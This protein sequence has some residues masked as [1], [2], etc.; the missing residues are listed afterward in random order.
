MQP[1]IKDLRQEGYKVRVIHT[2]L[3]KVVRRLMGDAFEVSSRGGSTTIEVTT[4]DKQYDVV[5]KSICSV[6]D[7][8]NRKV[9]NSIALGRALKNL[10]DLKTAEG[11]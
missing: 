4:P 3:Q 9:G 2:R 11:L 7:N 1:T 10:E 5:G 8:F 6:E